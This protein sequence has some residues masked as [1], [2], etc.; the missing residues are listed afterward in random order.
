MFSWT[1][2]NIAIFILCPDILSILLKNNK[3][4]KGIT[5]DSLEYLISQYADDTTFI[6][7][8][9]SESLNNAMRVLLR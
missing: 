7:Y 4:I 5:I 8:G 9:S 3:G 1:L 6:F 2:N